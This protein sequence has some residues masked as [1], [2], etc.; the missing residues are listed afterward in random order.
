MGRCLNCIHFDVCDIDR[1]DMERTYGD[2]S[3]FLNDNDVA[4][5]NQQISVEDR[6]PTE[7]DGTVLVCMPDLWPYN[8]KEPYVNAK[9]DCRV[10]VGHYSEHSNEWTYEL[11]MKGRGYLPTHWMPLPDPYT[12]KEN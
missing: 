6:L 9:H 4:P 7:S 1:R 11:G 3:D 5:K 8:N 2:C 12:E 10:R